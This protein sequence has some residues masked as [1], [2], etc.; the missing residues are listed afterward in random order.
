MKV[1]PRFIKM[2]SY[3]TVLQSS[4]C[5][6]LKNKQTKLKLHLNKEQGHCN[7]QQVLIKHYTCI[8]NKKIG[9]QLK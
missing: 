9:D 5:T 8:I 2:Y 3:T 7:E 1:F 6:A 4:K